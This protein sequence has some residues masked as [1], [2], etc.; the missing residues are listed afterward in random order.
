MAEI[1]II[2]SAWIEECIHCVK[3]TIHT[4]TNLSTIT[5]YY[6]GDMYNI[7]YT[8]SQFNVPTSFCTK[9]G[10]D[11][12]SAQLWNQLNEK[13]VML[14]GPTVTEKMQNQVIIH[15]DNRVLTFWEGNE[16]FKF[17]VDGLYPHTAFA[18]SDYV[19][20]DV[21]DDKVLELL[22]KKSPTTKWI[23]S[24]HVPSKELF[25]HVEGLIL[26]YEDALKLGKATDFDR[27]CYRLCELGAKWIIIYM[28]K[29]GI[30][31]YS[32]K[33][34][35]NYQSL[36]KDKGFDSGCYSGF[37]SGLLYGLTTYHDFH[38]AVTI[39]TKVSACIYEVPESTRD[40]IQEA[41]KQY[42]NVESF[43]Y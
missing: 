37:I 42:D 36:F 43:I 7:A 35:L 28:G 9:Y 24:R 31:A 14:Y 17:D 33:K 11:L 19:V 8:M 26:T 30:Y 3:P 2:G 22:F 41:I 34:P 1:S 16:A 4:G 25:E 39:G 40:D 21:T 32:F 5:R 6:S 27:I 10:N 20:T 13:N 15:S 12:D 29:Q 18:K 38:K 23:V